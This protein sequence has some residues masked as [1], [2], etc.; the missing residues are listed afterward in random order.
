MPPLPLQVL[1]LGSGSKFQLL[2]HCR[3]Y[4]GTQK[5]C[6]KSPGRNYFAA[7]LTRSLILGLHTG[8]QSS[9]F[10]LFIHMLI[11]QLVISCDGLG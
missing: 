3:A 10:V 2:P 1:W 11:T 5:H 4:T 8:F 9:F 7:E 6:P